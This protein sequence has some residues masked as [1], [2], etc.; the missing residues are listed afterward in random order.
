MHEIYAQK[1]A[2]MHKKHTLSIRKK[3][4]N[5]LCDIKYTLHINIDT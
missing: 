2:N 4:I 3:Y 5:M 1:N